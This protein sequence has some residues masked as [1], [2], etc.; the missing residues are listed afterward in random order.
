MS[1]AIA[2]PAAAEIVSQEPR[3]GKSAYKPR[4]CCECGAEFVPNR[5]QQQFCTPKHKTEFQNRAAAEGRALVALAKA[6]R[7][8]RG[9]GETAKAA[10]KEFVSILDLFNAQDRAAG[11]PNPEAYAAQLLKQGRYIDRVRP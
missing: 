3:A 11:R 6:W 10:F 1:E 5:P 4:V 8:K 7:A 2:L 9:S